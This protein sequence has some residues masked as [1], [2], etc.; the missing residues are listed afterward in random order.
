MIGWLRRCFPPQA[1]DA[2]PLPVPV[3]EIAPARRSKHKQVSNAA[4]VRRELRPRRAPDACTI[5]KSRG[6]LEIRE[7][8]VVEAGELGSYLA[9]EWGWQDVE[10]IGWLR[11][12]RKK[13]PQALWSVEEVTVVTSR[14][15]STT[16]PQRFLRLM[17]KHWCIEN[18]VHRVRDVTFQ[19]DRLHGRQ[20]GGMLAWLRNMAL[21][22]IR[23]YRP[24]HFIPDVCSELAANLPIALRWLLAPLMN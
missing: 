19:E 10:Q 23:R 20:I 5:E 3:C 12:W 8:W 2:A 15:L 9:Q 22:L 7:L 14:S 21:N 17:R 11:R 18:R 24:N 4:T 6:R 1:G 16:P 13:R